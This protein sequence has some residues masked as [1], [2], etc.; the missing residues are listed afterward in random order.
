MTG[1]S[2]GDR[3]S[4]APRS[5]PISA[6]R[7]VLILEIGERASSSCQSSG[8]TLGEW[9]ATSRVLDGASKAGWTNRGVVVDHGVE[10]STY[11]A[12]V[13]RFWERVALAMSA[14]TKSL[15]RG[16]PFRRRR[17]PWSGALESWS[18]ESG[19]VYRSWRL[20]LHSF[21]SS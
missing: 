7:P 5:R 8:R 10:H 9:G 12:A 16:K 13:G 18:A 4:R 1:R 20:N 6:E 3:Y 11:A 21:R 17:T 19:A 14:V 2:N 15:G